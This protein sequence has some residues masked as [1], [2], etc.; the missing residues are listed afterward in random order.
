MHKFLAVV[1][2]LAMLIVASSGSEI[3]ADV[4]LPN[5]P[6]GSQYE[7][8]FV[9]ADETT[10]TSTDISTYNSF[11]TA[12][13]N[14]DPIL[15]ALGVTW[16]AVA[17]TASIN[18]ATNAPSSGLP[19]YNTGGGEVAAAGLYTANLLMPI[20]DTQF[21]VPIIIAEDPWTGTDYTGTASTNPLGS[22]LPWY[23]DAYTTLSIWAHDFGHPADYPLPVFALSS[24]ITV[25]LSPTP[26]PAT[27][28]I[29]GS[30][31]LMYGA[32]S[33]HRWRRLGHE[34]AQT[35]HRCRFG[36]QETCTGVSQSFTSP[37]EASA[38]G[39]TN[40]AVPEDPLIMCS[41]KPRA[42]PKHRRCGRGLRIIL[43]SA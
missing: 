12:E 26:E 3:F 24:P 39:S 34:N 6:A 28:M 16:Q 8:I 13:A 19:V 25:P 37:E 4:I 9:T 20:K 41:S 5:L 14:S 21:G 29:L 43:N 15:A 11:V 40:Y 7:L 35:T 18:A 33:Y 27:V 32:I 10:A 23:G 22:S 36:N 17:S 42:P 38:F 2:A 30:I 1:L 31:C